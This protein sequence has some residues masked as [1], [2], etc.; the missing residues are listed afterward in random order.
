MSRTALTYALIPALILLAAAGAWSAEPQVSVQAELSTNT[1]SVGDRVMLI[2]SATHGSDQ[3]VVLEPIQREPFIAVWDMKA[4]TRDEKSGGKT[5]IHTVTFSSFVIGQHLVTASNLLLLGSN[6]AEDRLPLP[7]LL[8]NVVSVL[9]NPPPALADI[10]PAVSIPG[11]AWKRVLWIMLLIVALALLCG[12]LFRW[13]LNKPKTVP[14]AKVI[15]PHEIALTALQALLAR[16][17]IESGKS[18]EFYVELSAIVRIYLEDRFDLHAPEQTTE[19]FIRASSHSSVLNP[20]H[21]MLTQAFLEQS[22]LVK[23]ARFEPSPEDMRTAWDA[24]ARLVRE[25][26]PA[27]V[28]Q[29]GGAP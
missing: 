7:E 20:D 27:P 8:I 19:E 26:I 10:K 23:F 13:W 15:A 11:T 12:W 18:Q 24:A 5:T 6:G 4:E 17:F 28:K 25:T 14:E 29:P 16:G 22:D 3:R 21:R 2:V 9:S 1:V